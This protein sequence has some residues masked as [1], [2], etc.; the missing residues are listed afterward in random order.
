[1]ARSIDGLSAPTAV[2]DRGALVGAEEFLDGQVMADTAQALGNLKVEVLTL[3][4]AVQLLGRKPR[5]AQAAVRKGAQAKPQR[6]QASPSKALAAFAAQ[7][8]TD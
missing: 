5:K 8:D 4:Q 6:A 2:L 3:E 7:T 1:M